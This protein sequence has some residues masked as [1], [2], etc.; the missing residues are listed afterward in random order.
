LSDYNP[1]TK[2][3]KVR[4][5]NFNAGSEVETSKLLL[6]MGFESLYKSKKALF[7]RYNFDELKDY[8]LGKTKDN[9]PLIVPSKMIADFL[10]IPTLFDKHYL[11]KIPCNL[12]AREVDSKTLIFRFE[13]GGG[14]AMEINLLNRDTDWIKLHVDE[15][16][17]F[18]V[19][20]VSFNEKFGL[21]TTQKRVKF[22]TS[23]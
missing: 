13:Y 22:K 6:N 5:P 11:S 20:P 18:S 23:S 1:E 12:L 2:T 19:H 17:I 10:I 7:N 21:P 9:W 15:K 4:V 8:L 14:I 3:F 16:T